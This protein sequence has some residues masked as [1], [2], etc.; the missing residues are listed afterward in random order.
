MRRTNIYLDDADL[1]ALRAVGSS[2][3][4]AVADLVRE[5]VAEWLEKHGVRR[6]DEGEWQRR[7]G[8]LLSRRER[9]EAE[10]GWDPGRVEADVAAAIAEV[11]EARA[12]RRR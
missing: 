4:R 9:V 1:Q 5:A 2:Q 7:F 12:A 11:R 8:E 6:I 3:G 10:A